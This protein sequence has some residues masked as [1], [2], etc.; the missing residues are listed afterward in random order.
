MVK[1][2]SVNNSIINALRELKSAS[3]QYEYGGDYDGLMHE[4]DMC[5]MGEKF[6][7][8]NSEHL[9]T[10]L[11]KLFNI[12]ITLNELNQMIPSVCTSLSMKC[13]QVKAKNKIDNSDFTEFFITLYD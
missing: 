9:Q 12:E 3:L 7:I 4:Y 8:I 6:N 2:D 5:F 1:I 10:T 13:M 11:K